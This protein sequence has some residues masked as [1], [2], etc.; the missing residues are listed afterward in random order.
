MAGYRRTVSFPAMT[1]AAKRSGCKIRS[2]SLPVRFHP[3]VSDMNDEVPILI[4]WSGSFIKSPSPMWLLEGV[5]YISSVIDSLL[6][7][8][9][10]PLSVEQLRDSPTTVL[11]SED[12]LRLADSYGS[13]RNSLLEL[14]P[15]Q[16]DMRTA[17][18]RQ[19]PSYV[20]LSIREQKKAAQIIQKLASAVQRA[21]KA[22]PDTTG[23]S[24]L[25]IALYNAMMA[26]SS[27]SA[28]VF[29][30]ISV[31]SDESTALAAPMAAGAEKPMTCIDVKW[32][33]CTL[34]RKLRV[35]KKEA[36][37]DGNRE[38]EQAR[39]KIAA[40]DNLDKLDECLNTME[41]S[42]ENVYKDLVNARVNLLNILSFR[43]L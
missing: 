3:V 24:T 20:D 21:A 15:L 16:A 43:S 14:A 35:K 2:L 39:A 12:L 18:R 36:I 27:A 30:G 33:M 17:L 40:M 19:D 6:R 10:H 13:F 29:V 11:I 9:N 4:S 38:E 7:L 23:M 37:T 31:L 28:I 1:A 5:K 22:R 32:I 26:L 34:N 8:M 41:I 25:P 42:C